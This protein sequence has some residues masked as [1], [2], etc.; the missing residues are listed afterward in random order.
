MLC[1]VLCVLLKRRRGS[2]R[3]SPRSPQDSGGGG[4]DIG[5][6]GSIAA[7]AGGKLGSRQGSEL[8]PAVLQVSGGV[9]R[10]ALLCAAGSLAAVRHTPD[11]GVPGAPLACCGPPIRR[12]RCRGSA[13]WL[14]MAEAWVGY[15]PVDN[16]LLRAGSASSRA[17][18]M[19]TG[20]AEHQFSSCR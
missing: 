12:R 16:P 10:T 1:T 3:S 8:D 4:G 11:H 14:Q 17:R 19:G 18:L 2:R 15:T 6:K 5:G 7:R 20:A 13:S 9:S